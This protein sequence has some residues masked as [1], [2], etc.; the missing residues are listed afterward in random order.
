[1][2]QL[3]LT[4]DVQKSFTHTQLEIV[5]GYKTNLIR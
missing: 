3:A 5:E 2:G 4:F 1:M